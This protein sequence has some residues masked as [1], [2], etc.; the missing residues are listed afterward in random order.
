MLTQRALGT[1]SSDNAGDGGVNAGG[2]VNVEELPALPPRDPPALLPDLLAADEGP[3]EDAEDAEDADAVEGLWARFHARDATAAVARAQRAAGDSCSYART[4][5]GADGHGG[6]GTVK[7]RRERLAGWLAEATHRAMGVLDDLRT[8]VARTSGWPAHPAADDG[9]ASTYEDCQQVRKTPSCMGPEVGPSSALSS[10]ISTG[11]CGP[12]CIFWTN[13]TPSSPQ[14]ARFN[15]ACVL[16]RFGPAGEEL[17]ASRPATD[18]VGVVEA[19]EAGGGAEAQ[20]QLVFDRFVQRTVAR[21]MQ[22]GLRVELA[23]TPPAAGHL[24]SAHTGGRH[25]VLLLLCLPDE[26][27]EHAYDLL[28]RH[29]AFETG[30]AEFLTEDVLLSPKAD[31]LLSR[32]ALETAVSRPS[33]PSGAPPV[34][35]QDAQPEDSQGPPAS[36][37]LTPT[38]S[39]FYGTG[40]AREARTRPHRHHVCTVGDRLSVAEYILRKQL[41]VDGNVHLELDY[42]LAAAPPPSG[43]QASADAALKEALAEQ[44]AAAVGAT[45]HEGHVS[46]SADDAPGDP[47]RCRF[48][49]AT[50]LCDPAGARAPG[51]LGFSRDDKCCLH[52][53]V[54]FVI[55]VSD[56]R[57]HQ[58][59]CRFFRRLGVADGRA[60]RN[61]ELPPPAGFQELTARVIQAPSLREEC[62]VLGCGLGPLDQLHD[63]A[64]PEDR[65]IATVF[66]LHN[67]H[68]ES[69]LATLWNAANP[70]YSCRREVVKSKRGLRGCSSA[71]RNATSRNMICAGAR[72]AAARAKASV[73]FIT[74]MVFLDFHQADTQSAALDEV[75][76][77]HGSGVAIYWAF[78]AHILMCMKVLACEAT[79][80]ILVVWLLPPESVVGTVI[81]TVFGL[82][83]PAVWAP[84]VIVKWAK[85]ED[86][87]RHD[88]GLQVTGADGES[89]GDFTAARLNTQWRDPDDLDDKRRMKVRPETWWRPWLKVLEALV[90][91]LFAAAL[92][93]ANLVVI[94]HD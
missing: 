91:V 7:Q 58:Q 38:I 66:P 17:A 6:G 43:W 85:V 74:R 90:V 25:T 64:W 93:C 13:L 51:R 50:D 40:S 44:W 32:A 22:A 24:I 88:W 79:L 21:F 47:G 94:W 33:M 72:N 26:P 61:I 73:R 1:L 83:V 39:A 69:D 30:I 59:F 20:R 86:G 70:F 89:S 10:C 42:T 29:R 67:R 8:Q 56:V 87:L 16:R 18:A 34:G 12:T 27:F 65:R 57:T 77:Y 49:L 41:V 14:H 81:E 11:I 2:A 84:L 45:L 46:F 54:L 9:R 78:T 23:P 36:P 3:V 55:N 82:L 80:V 53:E 63:R 52:V 31:T 92:S 37:R 19:A 75:Q 5:G 48:R 60:S 15:F 28:A 68:H 4:A 71:A 76:A 62:E 35:L